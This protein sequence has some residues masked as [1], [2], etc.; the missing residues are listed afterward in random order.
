MQLV[1]VARESSA[2]FKRGTQHVYIKPKEDV[3]IYQ[4]IIECGIPLQV[5]ISDS[6]VCCSYVRLNWPKDMWTIFKSC[7]KLGDNKLSDLGL[8]QCTQL[9]GLENAPIVKFA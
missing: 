4:I 8:Y 6:A 7:E 2:V 9:P 3:Y 5:H 1:L